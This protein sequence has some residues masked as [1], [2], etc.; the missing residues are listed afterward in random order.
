MLEPANPPTA[1]LWSG[2]VML[3]KAEIPIAVLAFPLVDSCNANDPTA[4]FCAPIPLSKALNPIATQKFGFIPLLNAFEP[5][6]TL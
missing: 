4:T 1:V 5:T 3:T 6:A 2:V